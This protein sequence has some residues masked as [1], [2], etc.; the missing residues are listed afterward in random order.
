[1]IDL[2]VSGAAGSSAVAL[3]DDGYND[4]YIYTDA[5]AANVFT[6]TLAGNGTLANPAGLVAGFTYMWVITQDGTGG[7]NLTYDTLFKFPGGTTPTLS[8][9]AGAVDL[10]SALYDGTSL[11]VVSQTGFS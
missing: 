10:L 8:T 9:A 6:V 1:L 11:L 2:H 7:W 4:G 3:V 5:S